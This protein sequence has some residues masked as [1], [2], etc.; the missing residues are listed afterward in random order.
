MLM[1]RRQGRHF[2]ATYEAF[3]KGKMTELGQAG[4]SSCPLKVS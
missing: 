3:E 1:P 4:P 2:A